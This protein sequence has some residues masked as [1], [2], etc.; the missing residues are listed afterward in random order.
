MKKVDLIIHKS[1]WLGCFS[2]FNKIVDLGLTLAISKHI[3]NL[4]SYA[5]TG[6]AS[7]LLSKSWL[8][9]LLLLFKYA[10]SYF[11]TTIFEIK[12][13]EIKNRYK[14][15]F[16]Q[17]IMG[18]RPHKLFSINQGKLL[19]TLSSDIG[20]YLNAFFSIYPILLSSAICVLTYFLALVTYSWQIAVFLLVISFVQI[21]PEF[22]LIN[23]IKKD[24]DEMKDNEAKM[25]DFFIESI[26]SFDTEKIYDS[27]NWR[28]KKYNNL[29]KNNFTTDNKFLISDRVNE[30]V[31]KIISTGLSVGCYAV[32]G[33]LFLRNY[34]SIE[35]ATSAIYLSQYVFSNVK[36]IFKSIPKI[37][38][39]H[40]AQNRIEKWLQNSDEDKVIIQCEIGIGGYSYSVGGKTILKQLD[41][42]A[43]PKENCLLIGDN[44]S[45]KTTILNLLSSFIVPE[46]EGRKKE[47]VLSDGFMVPQEDPELNITAKKLFELFGIEKSEKMTSIARRLGL[48]NELIESNLIE[49]LSGGERKKVFLSIGFGYEAQWLL[50]D[51]PTNNLDAF[52]KKTLIELLSERKGVICVSHDKELEIVFDRK[53]RVENGK[54]QI[55]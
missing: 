4:V 52:G 27:N 18:Q 44:G 46:N 39:S 54:A 47:I 15:S 40:K 1:Q 7:G 3:S 6:I 28:V 41:F 50:L 31:N 53:W 5:M 35:T 8:L 12:K 32:V 30:S 9:F 11:T 23:R 10:Y 19:K 33:M 45:G 55:A 14:D 21:I 20:T 26:E 34:C 43:N 48:A 13:E 2:A 42:S 22:I 38:K 24:Y 17:Q 36:S 49:E 37:S 51:E 25:T 16:L 29:A